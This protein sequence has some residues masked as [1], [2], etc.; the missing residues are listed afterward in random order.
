VKAATAVKS[1]AAA[2]TTPT[3]TATVSNRCHG[4]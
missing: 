2:M 3:S 4:T 1:T